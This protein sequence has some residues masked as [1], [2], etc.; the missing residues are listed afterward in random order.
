MLI[1]SIILCINFNV[2]IFFENKLLLFEIFFLKNIH[3][4]KFSSVIYI[5]NHKEYY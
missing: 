4:Q 1:I 5:L 2:D 3:S